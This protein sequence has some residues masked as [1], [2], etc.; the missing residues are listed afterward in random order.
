MYPRTTH[1]IGTGSVLRTSIARPFELCGVRR[2]FAREVLRRNHVMR[3]D[4]G[5]LFEPEQRE[6]RQNAALIGNRRGQ[7]DVES[8][9]TIRRHDQQAVAKVVDVANLPASVELEPRK[10]CLRNNGVHLRRSHEIFV[11]GSERRVF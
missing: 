4:S 10:I 5:E 3:D 1:S 11:L 6:L 7:N 8:R 2:E 9:K